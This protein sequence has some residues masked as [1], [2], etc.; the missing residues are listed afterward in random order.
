M[1][2][3]KCPGPG[4]SWVS[5]PYETAQPSQV[6]QGGDLPEPHFLMGRVTLPTH[7]AS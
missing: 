1:R 5:I 4:G 6:C 2:A 7:T 3:R